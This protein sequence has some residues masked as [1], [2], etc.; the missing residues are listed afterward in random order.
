MEEEAS[1]SNFAGLCPDSVPALPKTLLARELNRG[2]ITA[3]RLRHILNDDRTSWAD[4]IL[5]AQGLVN[6]ILDSFTRSISILCE[7]EE[8]G[9]AGRII[10]EYSE[11]KKPPAAR[12]EKRGCYKRRK[13]SDT[14][15]KESATLFDDGHAWRKYGQKVILNAKHPRN[16][17]RCT[18]KFDQGC[19]ASKQVQK[20]Q[21]DPP[22]YRTT[23]QDQHTCTYIAFKLS[24]EQDSSIIWN[25]GPGQTEQEYSREDNR[26][27]TESPIYDPGYLDGNVFSPDVYSCSASTHSM[28]M[29]LDM[30]VIDDFLDFS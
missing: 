10:E 29:D 18:H 5:P 25:F 20:I 7:S 21:D 9:A 12:K 17:F 19:R 3:H 27:I 26:V 4:S 22:L 13:S 15:I 23:Y 14:W 16:Y 11:S 28:E 2:R 30:Y 24:S 6:E 8:V 1:S